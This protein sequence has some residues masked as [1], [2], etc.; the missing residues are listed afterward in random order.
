M[1][2]APMPKGGGALRRAAELV[3][4]VAVAGAALYLT[5][6]GCVFR[7]VTGVP[8]PGCGMTRAWL[9]ALRLD[10]PAALAYHPLFWTV[11]FMIALVCVQERCAQVVRNSQLALEDEA[12][13][14][15]ARRAARVLSLYHPVLVVLIGALLV[16][17]VVRLVDPADAGLLFGGTAPAGVPRDI[18]FVQKPFWLVWFD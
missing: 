11:P 13:A 6:I 15:A 12:A 3:A 17:W 2:G 10:L 9:A 18:I 1:G 8:C 5:D 14:R 4:F 16:L 7:T